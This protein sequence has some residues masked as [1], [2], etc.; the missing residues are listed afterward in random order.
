MVSSIRRGFSYRATARKF[1]VSVGTV[2]AW[3]ERAKGRRLDRVDWS[4]RPD[5]CRTAVNRT[6]GEREDQMLAIRQ[7]L[8]CHSALG[9][10]GA[11]AI[12]RELITRGIKSPSSV[13]TIGRILLRRGAL[14][15]RRR[16][17]RSPPPR[18]WYLPDVATGGAEL[19]SFDIVEGLAFKGGKRFEVFNGISLHGGLVTSW[20][21][22]FITAKMA[23]EMLV[24]HWREVGIPA[25]AQFDNDTIFH[26]P[27]I[28]A[29]VFSRVMRL[30]LSLGVTPVF[31]PPRE[32]G[33]QASIERYNGVWQEKVWHRFR[34]ES[35]ASLKVRSAR[36]VEASRERARMRIDTAPE[37]RPFPKD[38]KL[39]LQAP[40][41]GRL[42]FI[43]RT[44]DKGA[45]NLLGHTF[46]VDNLW[47]HRLVRCEVNLT[48]ESI[49]F[50]SLRR[51]EPTSQNLLK[52][53]SYSPPRRR[54]KE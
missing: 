31:V 10:F 3:V 16:V 4:D 34:H 39:N 14:D 5:G 22:P 18:G 9:E 26:G 20:P 49:G 44:N 37:R 35:L 48:N 21:I 1:G 50:Y 19:D 41:Q 11:T 38:W 30:C 29:D 36:Y 32:T 27:H 33:F 13:R 47:S 8:R 12:R 54:F 7:E 45:V 24:S 6:H 28:H 2:H 46:V 43:R 52:E 15:G 23:A 53:V 42:V 17:R 40:L 51:R 25:Y